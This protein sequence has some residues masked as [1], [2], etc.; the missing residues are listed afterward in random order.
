[1]RHLISLTI[2]MLLVSSQASAEWGWYSGDVATFSAANTSTTIPES[3]HQA[4]EH[5]LDWVVLSTP[6]GSGEFVGLEELIN[7][8][9]LTVPR[10]TPILGAGWSRSRPFVRILGVDARAPVPTLFSDLLTTVA[11]HGGVAILESIDTGLADTDQSIIFSPVTSGRWTE[12]V[13]PRGAWDQALTDGR[14]AFIASTSSGTPPAKNHR[15]VLWAEGNQTDHLVKSL[16]SGASYVTEKGGIAIDLQVDGRSFGQTVFHRGEV[17]VRIKAYARDTISSVSLIAN[18]EEVWS[19]SPKTNVWEARFFLPVGDLGY[20]R[21]V[22]VSKTGGY[23]TVGNPIF[24]V[25]ESPEDGELPIADDQSLP[26]DGLVEMSGLLEASIGLPEDAQAR[27][28]REFLAGITTRY[29]TCWLLQ[30]RTDIVGDGVLMNLAMQDPDTAVRLGAAYALVVRSSTLAPDILLHFLDTGRPELE[31]YAARMFAQYTEGFA[32]ADWAWSERLTSEA[33]AFMI[34]AYQPVRFS[35]DQVGVIIKALGS[36]EIITTHAAQDK[37]IE[38]GTRHYR[39]IQLLLDAVAS[40]EASAADVIGQIGDHRT[41]GALQNLFRNTGTLDVRRSVF[42]ALDRMGAPYPNRLTLSLAQL[43]GT[44][45]LDGLVR[46]EEWA[47]ASLLETLKSDLN[48]ETYN[49]PGLAIRAGHQGDSVYVSITRAQQGDFPVATLTDSI[50]QEQSD[51]VIEL[52]LAAPPYD[53][54]ESDNRLKIRINALGI[55]ECVKNVCRAVSRVTENAWE[56]EIAISTEAVRPY[57]RFNIAV[58]SPG[59]ATRRLA[60][61]VTYGDPHNPSRFGDLRLEEVNSE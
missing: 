37:L 4:V 9:S 43:A 27:I 54:A 11:S 5:G 6:P 15:T 57:P 12:A 39:V 46:E 59:D 34:R 41:V 2:S 29:G 30:N 32:E 58:V 1:M 17:F 48:G 23:R 24:L 50:N 20:V 60:W 8:A 25:S 35:E 22:L 16:K 21:P 3:V 42:L 55:V 38:L 36:T 51:D 14:R 33:Q 19:T 31:T 47:S 10:L 40:G 52:A 13:S 49:L 7:E 44:P 18:G 45:T 53:R 26:R 28:L 61:S 56:I